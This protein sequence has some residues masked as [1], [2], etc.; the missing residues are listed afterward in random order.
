VEFEVTSYGV[1]ATMG[2]GA[3]GA[4]VWQVRRTGGDW[5]VAQRRQPAA[6]FRWQCMT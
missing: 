2:R 5:P 6:S 3:D 4:P 1:K